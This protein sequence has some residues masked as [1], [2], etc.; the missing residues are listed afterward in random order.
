MRIIE[1]KQ[2]FETTK[3]ETNKKKNVDYSPADVLVQHSKHLSRNKINF[4]NYCIDF[5]CLILCSNANLPTHI[6]YLPKLTVRHLEDG[7]DFDVLSAIALY[8]VLFI[9]V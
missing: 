1:V 7:I 6:Q 2:C 4:L 3:L 5:F 8:F 9:C